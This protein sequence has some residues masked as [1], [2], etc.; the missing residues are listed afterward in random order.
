MDERAR[1][2]LGPAIVVSNVPDDIVSITNLL[3]MAQASAKVRCPDRVCLSLIEQCITRLLERY[4]LSRTQ[5]SDGLRVK[6]FVEIPSLLRVLGYARSEAIHSLNDA[7]CADILDE[8]IERLSK[9]H[10]MSQVLYTPTVAL[11]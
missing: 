10:E 5:L 1:P 2:N 3:L 9:T 4:G 8:C 11:N 6:E 7:D